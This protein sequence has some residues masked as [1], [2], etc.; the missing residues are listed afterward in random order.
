M[1]GQASK[2]TVISH[3]LMSGFAVETKTNLFLLL[4]PSWP[5]PALSCLSDFSVSV[6]R[7]WTVSAVWRLFASTLSE[8]TE[9]CGDRLGN[10]KHNFSLGFNMGKSFNLL[11]STLYNV[12]LFQQYKTEI[13][14]PMR[15]GSI[16][17]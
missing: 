7:N 11:D 1:F 12:L 16:P 17:P 8:S 15:I 6:Y 4:W 2:S 3:K 10:L 9:F 5:F 13:R 14:Y